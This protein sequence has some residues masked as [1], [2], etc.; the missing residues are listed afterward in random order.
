M[1]SAIS[2]GALDSRMT[3]TASRTRSGADR[4]CPELAWKMNNAH[5][6]VMSAPT[7]ANA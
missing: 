4:M 2:I 5:P 7:P 6:A 3:P 1:L